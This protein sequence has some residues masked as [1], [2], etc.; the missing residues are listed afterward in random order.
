[1][2]IEDTGNAKHHIHEAGRAINVPF[3]LMEELDV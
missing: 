3:G 2:D 1:M